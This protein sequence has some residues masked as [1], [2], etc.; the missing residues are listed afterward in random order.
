MLLAPYLVS[1]SRIK[2]P[3]FLQ[4]GDYFVFE[5]AI[6]RIKRLPCAQF[7][8][9]HM[10][11]GF[12]IDS[13]QDAPSLSF[14]LNERFRVMNQYNDFPIA[15]ESWR[16]VIQPKSKFTMAIILDSDVVI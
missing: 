12:L 11:H 10:F 5:D 14:V 3:G 4:Y 13:F 9:W 16:A 6:G 15:R 7:Q 8:H 1:F 2:I